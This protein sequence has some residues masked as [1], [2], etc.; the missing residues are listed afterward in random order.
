MLAVEV[1]RDDDVGLDWG[2]RLVAIFGT[3]LG[4]A[5]DLLLETLLEARKECGAAGQD[6]IVI[7]VNLEIVIAFF[8]CLERNVRQPAHLR[9]DQSRVE[10][11]LS[12]PET[13][14]MA[15][16]NDFVTWKL[17]RTLLLVKWVSRMDGAFVVEGNGAHLFLH[18]PY[19]FEVSIIVYRNLVLN[20][21]ADQL[22][23]DVLASDVKFMYSMWH[24]V[25]LENGHSVADT[26]T[27]LNNHA[28]SLACGE[29]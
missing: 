8:N 23:G 2:P 19:M 1:S 3:L 15:H 6:D 25:A 21:L 29:E 4:L 5:L 28:S 10:D 24:C 13:L 7:E 22:I 14:L 11:Y 27:A 17:V 16:L 20:Q 18:V 12:R 26:L 9:P